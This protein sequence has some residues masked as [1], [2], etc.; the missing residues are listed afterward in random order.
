MAPEALNLYANSEVVTSR[1]VDEE[2]MP[3]YK[4]ELRELV[5]QLIGLKKQHEVISIVGMPGLVSAPP[6]S[7]WAPVTTA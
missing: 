4:D 2:E 7:H 6:A 1:N 3:G 5:N